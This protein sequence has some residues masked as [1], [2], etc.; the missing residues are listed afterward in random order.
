MPSNSQINVSLG[1]RRRS[2]VQATVTICLLLAC[3]VLI[4]RIFEGGG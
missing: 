4:F 1:Y 2:A 3:Y